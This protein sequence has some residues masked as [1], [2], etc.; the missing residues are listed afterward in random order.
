MPQPTVPPTIGFVGLGSMGRPTAE[1]LVR[2][3]LP[4]VVFDL[5]RSIVDDLVGQG[6]EGADSLPDLA[7]RVHVVG[8]CV[9]AAAHVRAV[10]DG[11]D[12]LLEHLDEGSVIAIHSTVLPETI[13]WADEQA[14]KHGIGVVEAAITGGAGAAAEGRS[15]FIVRGSAEHLAAV[16]PLFEACADDRVVVDGDLGD[17]TRLKLC[18]NLQTYATFTGVSEAANLALELGLPIDALR[19]AMAANG[20][21]GELTETFMIAYDMDPADLRTPEARK[22]LEAYAAIIDKDLELVSKLAAEA[23]TPDDTAT[24]ARRLARRVYFLDDE[25]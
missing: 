15:P 3:G 21:L 6:A 8:V 5:D 14:A 22:E 23:G 13:E 2:E 25:S 11:P 16:E 10:L 1:C 17:A 24:L 7:R 9:P 19:S 12:G 4:T 20:Q 18:L